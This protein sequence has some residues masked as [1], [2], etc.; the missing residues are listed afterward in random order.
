[1]ASTE[2][3]EE[4]SGEPAVSVSRIT[5]YGLLA[6]VLAGLVNG[7]VRVLAL[8]VFDVPNVFALWW[9]PV[10]IASAV[11]AIGATI[12]YVLLTRVSGRPNRAFTIVAVL[13][14]VLSFAGP[15][16]AL[17]SPPPELADAPWTVFATLVA[18]HVAAAVTIISVL[19]RSTN[20]GGTSR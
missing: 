9:E 11:G 20:P 2:A 18:M 5:A 6:V 3:T 4:P 13:V 15:L 1:M 7:V 14:L 19:T 8:T 16:S 17:L 12:V 10:L